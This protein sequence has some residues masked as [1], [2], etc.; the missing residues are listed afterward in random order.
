DL[1][2]QNATL[3]I[4]GKNHL[5]ALWRAFHEHVEG[6][7]RKLPTGIAN[8][9][10]SAAVVQD[11]PHIV[12]EASRPHRSIRLRWSCFGCRRLGGRRLWRWLLGSGLLS[13]GFLSARFLH[14][15][16]GGRFS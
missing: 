14:G 9:T 3:H 6:V 12:H 2:D 15:R 11:R 10:A 1:L 4:A 5:A 8:V 7:H 16:L 13:V